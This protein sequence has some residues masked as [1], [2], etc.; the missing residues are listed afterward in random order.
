MSSL[1]DL[2]LARQ[3]ELIGLARRRLEA[4]HDQIVDI[5]WYE[6]SRYASASFRQAAAHIMRAIEA[7]NEGDQMRGEKG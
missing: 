2:E 7:L 3:N 6:E 5:D 4:V 1:T